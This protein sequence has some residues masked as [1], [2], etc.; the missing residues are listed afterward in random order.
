V[1]PG[2]YNAAEPP[3]DLPTSPLTVVAREPGFLAA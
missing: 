3:A 1:A 2:G